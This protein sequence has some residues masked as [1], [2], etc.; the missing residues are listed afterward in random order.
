[1]LNA[2]YYAGICVELER[3]NNILAFLLSNYPQ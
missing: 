2:S 1:M 3:K